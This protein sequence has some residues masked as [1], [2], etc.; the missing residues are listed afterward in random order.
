MNRKKENYLF[1]ERNVI[2]TMPRKHIIPEHTHFQ[3]KLGLAKCEMDA[4]ISR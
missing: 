2:L 3:I 4:R 1:G